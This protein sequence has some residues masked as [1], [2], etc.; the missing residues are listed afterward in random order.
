MP[1]G[2]RAFGRRALDSGSEARR[3]GCLGGRRSAFA[4]NLRLTAHRRAARPKGLDRSPDSA[5]TL[6]SRG[7]RLLPP[8]T[9]ETPRAATGAGHVAPAGRNYLDELIARIIQTWGLD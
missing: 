9:R 6:R 8:V 2:H 4:R 1:Q 7:A 3:A 5:Q